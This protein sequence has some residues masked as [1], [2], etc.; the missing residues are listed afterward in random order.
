MT[1]HLLQQAAMGGSRAALAV[2]TQIVGDS[3]FWLGPY[4]RA[5]CMITNWQRIW[6]H[7]MRKFQCDLN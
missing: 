6:D 5:L 7:V 2:H 4:D 1:N 3:V